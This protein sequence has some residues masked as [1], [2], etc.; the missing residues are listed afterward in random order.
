MEFS[1]RAAELTT[2]LE[3]RMTNF[4]TN[5]QVDE[6]GRVVSVG[7]GIA[8]VYGLNEIQAGEMVEFAS[9]VK[10][11]A[12]NLILE[13]SIW[14]R[15]LIKILG[16]TAM[17]SGSFP[18]PTT[19]LVL[20]CI[21]IFIT[22]VWIHFFQNKKWVFRARPKA[23]RNLFFFFSFFVSL[24]GSAASASGVEDTGPSGS[25]PAG[26]SEPEALDPIPTVEFLRTELKTLFD[27]EK[28]T[29]RSDKMIASTLEEMLM[30]SADT[31]DLQ[32]AHSLIKFYRENPGE[33]KSGREKMS[34]VSLEYS[35]YFRKKYGSEMYA[36][37]SKK[38]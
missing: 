38:G 34:A 33:L 11:I 24:F 32:K 10:G 37:T 26:A 12:L 2:L 16:K 28:T 4:Y 27:N 25:K 35:F 20:L 7:D 1:P 30:E 13:F 19:P 5:F 23:I 36:Q 21:C 9:G 6:I 31:E 22:L 3:S 8:R 14:E 15:V 18:G 17:L 29:K